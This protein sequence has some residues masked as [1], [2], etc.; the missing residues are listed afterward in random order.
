MDFSWMLI[1]FHGFSLVFIDFHGFVMDFHWFSW[2]LM[3][4]MELDVQFGEF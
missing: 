1:D 3:I 4:L 2:I